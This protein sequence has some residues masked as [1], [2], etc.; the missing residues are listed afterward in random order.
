MIDPSTPGFC[1]GC[2]ATHPPETP[3]CPRSGK[4]LGA[5]PCGTVVDRYRVESLLG[6]GGMGA[7]YRAIHEVLQQPVALKLLH[8]QLASRADLR[9]RFVR[10]ARAAASLT[11][12]RVVRVT[13][14]G[15]TADGTAFL[16]M[17]ILAGET[18]EALMGRERPMR[19]ERAVALMT[20]VLGAL[21][22]AHE[23]GIIHR[24][25][26]PANVFVVRDAEGRESVKLL[27]FGI[28]KTIDAVDGTP[29]TRTGLLVGTPLYMAPEQVLNARNIDRRADVYAA[30]VILYQMLSGRLPVTGQ[31]TAEIL[32]K[33]VTES[34]AP[35]AQVAPQVP[36]PLVEVVDTAM[37]RDPER[38]FADAKVFAQALQSA[39]ASETMHAMQRV[40]MVEAVQRSMAPSREAHAQ[41]AAGLATTAPQ[42]APGPS[43]M[44][45]Q[46]P[47][48][49]A[50]PQPFPGPAPSP[51]R[52]PAKVPIWVWMLAGAVGLLALLCVIGMLV[53]A[54][55]ANGSEQSGEGPRESPTPTVPQ[56]SMVPTAPP[57]A[58]PSMAPMP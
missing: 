9:E 34:P 21:G 26:K 25:L 40:S 55:A 49:F 53:E 3:F 31:A 52:E 32:V 42:T 12:P 2:G 57:S 11:D 16:A 15:I 4:L 20:E 43:T 58:Q 45:L 22:A 33:L 17:E 29:L 44:P 38:R 48:G 41:A 50:P 56:P 10:E 23:K 51:P 37:A 28:S 1:R 18:L 54:P 7:V 13:D 5:G 6:G 36:R 24:D 27:D 8:P 30:G 14:C 39:L 35:L 19:F 47:M 46:P